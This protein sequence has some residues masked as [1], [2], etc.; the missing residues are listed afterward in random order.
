MHHEWQEVGYVKF[1]TRG[2][3]WLGFLSLMM[4]FLKK[5]LTFTLNDPT[6]TALTLP[7]IFLDM[8]N[9]SKLQII[10]EIAN[11]WVISHWH[12]RYQK[13]QWTHWF[14]EM[15]KFTLWWKCNTTLTTWQVGTYKGEKTRSKN[16][17]SLLADLTCS[18]HESMK[19]HCNHF[20]SKNMKVFAKP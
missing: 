17:T 3:S 19:S 5:Q 14:L 2:Q 10:S 11:A 20:P 4:W 1:V 8:P 6:E 16:A 18:E 12:C 9:Q 7:A 15:W 13:V